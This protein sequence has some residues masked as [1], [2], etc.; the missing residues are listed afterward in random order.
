MELKSIASVIISCF[1]LTIGSPEVRTWCRL[2]LL[3]DEDSRIPTVKCQFKKQQQK[4]WH[5]ECTIWKYIFQLCS[6]LSTEN[7]RNVLLTNYT[8]TTF[9]FAFQLG[10]HPFSAFASTCT[11]QDR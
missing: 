1:F 8:N 7:K 4:N 2:F 10:V 11:Y 5:L 6:V 9:E 3:L